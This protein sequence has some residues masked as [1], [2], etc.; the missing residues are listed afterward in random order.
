M[1]KILITGGNGFIGSHLAERLSKEYSICIFDNR[2]GRFNYNHDAVFLRGDIRN[3]KDISKFPNNLDG[4]VHL[5]AVSRVKEGAKD[6]GKCMDTNVAGTMNILEFVRNKNPWFILG[7]TNELA[8]SN[9]YGLSKYTSELY[10]ERYSEDYGIKALVLKLAS[11][12]GS[13]RDNPEKLIPSLINN[14][15]NNKNIIIDNGLKTFDLIYIEDL[16]NGIS[17]GIDYLKD[18]QEKYFDTISLCT[19]KLTNLKE[20]SK[21]I[22]KETGSNSRVIIENEQEENTFIPDPKKAENI[23][24][25]KAGINIE[26]GIKRTIQDLRKEYKNEKTI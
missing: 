23:L 6:P 21:L 7:S 18:I 10:S 8:H 25:F 5:A 15:K 9:I 4:I 22:I 17:K 26:E 3:K 14:A 11:V 2:E 20:L 16:I 24:K 12:Y 1:K 13:E 19:G